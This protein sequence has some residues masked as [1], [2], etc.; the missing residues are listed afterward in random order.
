VTGSPQDA[1]L[2]ALRMNN[3]I[4]G[5]ERVAVLGRLIV[6]IPV[7]SCNTAGAQGH[8]LAVRPIPGIGAQAVPRGVACRSLKVPGF[9]ANPKPQLGSDRPRI[10]LRFVRT[11]SVIVIDYSRD[12][13]RLL[14]QNV[15][16]AVRQ[17][18][19]VFDAGPFDLIA[20][21]I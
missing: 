3:R 11:L 7:A 16:T 5:C 1:R 10:P 19:S 20:N 21:T 6:P 15:L 18:G 2:H 4:F 12:N 17:N 8:A 14:T 9:P 13:R